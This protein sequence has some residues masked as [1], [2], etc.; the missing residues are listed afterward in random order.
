MFK[1]LKLNFSYGHHFSQAFGGYHQIGSS[2]NRNGDKN[3]KEIDWDILSEE[4]VKTGSDDLL[5]ML[6]QIIS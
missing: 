1:N 6:L 4:N 2:F 3:Y 5:D